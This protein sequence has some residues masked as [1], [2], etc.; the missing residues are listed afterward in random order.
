MSTPDFRRFREFVL[1]EWEFVNNIHLLADFNILQTGNIIY[2]GQSTRNAIEQPAECQNR[3]Y[4]HCERCLKQ[5]A[6]S[7]PQS[8]S[9]LRLCLV[10]AKI[11]SLVEIG[12]MWRKSLKFTCVEKC[13]AANYLETEYRFATAKTSYLNAFFAIS[14]WYPKLN[15]NSKW[16]KQAILETPTECKIIKTQ[17]VTGLLERSKKIQISTITIADEQLLLQRRDTMRIA[18]R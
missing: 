6:N 17:T 3:D 13:K 1:S 7:Q 16:R 18:D 4:S 2:S 11:G 8:T 12:M 5:N 15:T 14:E 10:H 9:H